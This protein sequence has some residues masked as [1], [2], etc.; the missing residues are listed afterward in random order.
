MLSYSALKFFTVDPQPQRGVRDVINFFAA[1]GVIA[2]VQLFRII[3]FRQLVIACAQEADSLNFRLRNLL[4]SVGDGEASIGRAMNQMCGRAH[5]VAQVLIFWLVELVQCVESAL[6][7]VLAD[8]LVALCVLAEFCHAGCQ[9]DQLAAV[10]NR[11]AGTIDGLI[12]EPCGLELAGIEIDHAFLNAVLDEVN[13]LLLRQLD[14]FR[15]AASSLADKQ[16][17]H[18][19]FALWGRA[20]GQDEQ[21]RALVQKVLHAVVED[22]PHGRM[23]FPHHAEDGEDAAGIIT[24]GLAHVTDAAK[25]PELLLALRGVNSN[26]EVPLYL[27]GQF[28][29]ASAFISGKIYRVLYSFTDSDFDEP[30]RCVE[31]NVDVADWTVVPVSPEF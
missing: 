17:V 29:N 31:L 9:N 25:N 4:Y 3:F 30:E 26:S 19:A 18:D 11:H 22:L 27:R 20:D 12:A 21:N 23:V 24:Y 15:Q 5:V 2:V 6:V 13:V 14:R 16:A 1:Y 28:T 7:A 8:E 10:G